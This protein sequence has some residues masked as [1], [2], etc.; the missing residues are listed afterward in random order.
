[1][2]KKGKTSFARE[3]EAAEI[4][5]EKWRKYQHFLLV[6]CEDQIT[7]PTYISTFGRSFPEHTLYLKVAGVG[8]DPLG[9]VLAAVEQR[10]QLAGLTK[11]EI[12]EVWVI[13]DKDDADYNQTRIDRFNKAFETA[14][15]NNFKIAWS[16]EVFELWFLLHFIDIEPAQPLPRQK[17]YERLKSIINQLVG[18]EVISDGHSNPEIIPYLTSHGSLA[19]AIARAEHLLLHHGATHPIAANPATRMHQLVTSL[20]DWIAYYNYDSS[21]NH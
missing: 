19:A 11:R 7:E 2:A 6:V 13:F 12:D 17:V 1:M 16:N 20:F 4:R 9:V 8:R 14:G 15:A 5:V 18:T 3:V 21:S 10:K